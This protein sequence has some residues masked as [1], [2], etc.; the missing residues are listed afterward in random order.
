MQA[1]YKARKLF[2]QVD[3][4]KKISKALHAKS[5][6]LREFHMGE[7]VY[8]FRKGPKEGSRYGDHWYGP[9]RV[10]THE[11]TGDF[12]EGQHLGSVVWVAH[13]GKIIRC[14]PEQL[15]LCAHDLRHLDLEI[16]GPQNIH[17]MLEQVSRQQKYFD[18][19][20][21][22]V[23]DILREP[24]PESEKPHFRAFGKTPLEHLQRA[25]IR[26]DL[27]VARNGSDQDIPQGP[28]G[29]EESEDP[30]LLADQHRRVGPDQVSSGPE[31]Q[32][33]E[34]C[35][36]LSDDRYNKWVAD[37]VKENPCSPQGVEL[38]AHYLRR[39][40]EMEIKDQGSRIKDPVPVRK[41]KC[42]P[43]LWT[44]MSSLNFGT[45]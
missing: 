20:K 31:V 23:S 36:D 28:H 14:S 37:H 18:I 39:R 29:L 26:V 11:K 13:A 7:L 38:Y 1:E 5:R 43:T 12:E 8:Y 3:A 6:P 2:L 9:A 24:C 35:R 44:S 34:L 16:D 40:L 32:R 25:P 21:E 4:Q 17:S 27:S 45:N 22:D 42:V 41:R 19:S 15:R 10:L 33:G 30:R